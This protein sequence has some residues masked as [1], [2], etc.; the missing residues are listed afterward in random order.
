[1]T[2]KSIWTVIL[3]ALFAHSAFAQS[4]RLR[5]LSSRLATDAS[6]F[7]DSTYQNYS[8]SF[9]PGRNDVQAA[10]L[11]QQFSAAAQLF[12]RMV[13][14]RKNSQ[15]LREGFRVLQDLARNV[16]RNNVQQ[17]RWY[18]IQ[19]TMSD[20]SRE[21]DYGPGPG[22]NYPP[23]GSSGRMTW[24]GRVD[25]DVRITIR[26]GS[27]DVETL[28]GTPYN[29]GTPNFSASLPYRRVN[30]RLNV[31]K[32]RGEVFIEEQPSRDN[33]FAAVIR[34]RDPKGGASDYEF[35]LSW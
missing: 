30:V 25:A 13:N 3:V 4:G 7:A 16:E 27:A 28:G 23:Q 20:I 32:G 33:N 11:A 1:M 12:N 6:D 34:I 18:S 14:D 17:N 29:D 31:R 5:D 26:G 21:V 8:G 15:D 19:T 24:K 22:D 9:R 2:I 10:M 35:E